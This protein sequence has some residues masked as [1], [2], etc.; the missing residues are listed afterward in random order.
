MDTQWN[1]EEESPTDIAV[2]A[3]SLDSPLPIARILLKRKIQ[4]LEQAK[5]FFRPNI[6]NLHDPFLMKD[7]DIAVDRIV[8]AKQNQENVVIYGDYDVDGT[9]SIALLTLFFKEIGL[10]TKYY[11]PKRLKEGYGLSKKAIDEI[12][13]WGTHLI[14]T[15]D[16]GITASDQVAHANQLGIDVIISDHHQPGDV[17]PSALAVLNPNQPG[18]EYPFKELAG[19]GVAFKL[20]QAIAQRLGLDHEYYC[21]HLDLAGIGSSADIVPLIDEN[22]I[23][24]HEGLKRINKSP[25]IGVQALLLQAGLFKKEIGTGQIV[26]SI[27]PRIN[28]AGRMGEANRA[29]DLLVTES[30]N[31]ANNVAAI[32]E[33]EN[34]SRRIVDEKIFNEACAILEEKTGD[35]KFI[36]L[37]QA[38]WHPG[39]IGIVASRLVEKFYRPTVLIAVENGVG[40]GSVRS[41]PGFNVFEALKSCEQLMLGFGGHKYAAGVKIESDKIPQLCQQLNEYADKNMDENLLIPKI[42][43]DTELNLDEMNSRFLKILKLFAPFGPQNMRPVFM[44]QNLEVV[45]SPNIVGKNHLRMKVRQNG[46]VIDAIGFNMGDLMYRV[47]TGKKNLDIVY[48]IEENEYLGRTNLQLRIKDLR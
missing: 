22:R 27:A 11:I 2:L 44:S 30:E 17:L 14:I 8:T 42:R 32:L 10:P 6:K 12:K 45:G 46:V 7:M 26:F 16:C 48:C 35:E 15:T 25:R 4:N 23:L 5:L 13:S 34:K 24:V 40:K 28:A 3:E 9:T 21:K 31:L 41:I 39:V 19:I 20:V 1:Y 43:I 47:E 29:V 33:T 38:G 18:C 37:S 36:V